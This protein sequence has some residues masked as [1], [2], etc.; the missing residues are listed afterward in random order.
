MKRF[1]LRVVLAAAVMLAG[2]CQ[3]RDAQPGVAQ[4]RLTG[5]GTVVPEIPPCPDIRQ[6]NDG[7]PLALARIDVC[8]RYANIVQVIYSDIDSGKITDAE[9]APRIPWLAAAMWDELT[10]L[11]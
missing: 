9:A 5:T 6:S 4:S 8:D 3:R 1:T 10:E 7:S 11:N 2:A